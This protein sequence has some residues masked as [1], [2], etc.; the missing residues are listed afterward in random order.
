LALE[1]ELNFPSLLREEGKKGK[2]ERGKKKKKRR[3]KR[4]SGFWGKVNLTEGG[5]GGSGKKR[6]GG[7]RVGDGILTSPL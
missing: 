6:K 7:T 4:R 1:K 3:G 5:G 2:E